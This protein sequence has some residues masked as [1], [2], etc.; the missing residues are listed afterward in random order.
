MTFQ[1]GDAP[2]PS[3]SALE[4]QR[5]SAE[6]PNWAQ[7]GRHSPLDARLAPAPGPVSA[8]GAK[9]R[10]LTAGLGFGERRGSAVSGPEPSHND[11]R[12]P[13]RRGCVIFFPIIRI[14]ARLFL[15]RPERTRHDRL[16]ARTRPLPRRRAGSAPLARPGFGAGWAVLCGDRLPAGSV[17]EGAMHEDDVLD[18]LG[19]CR[20]DDRR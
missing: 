1:V 4:A 6:R 19:P 16:R 11:D 14:C 17:G 5:P 15:S 13:D 18:R 7:T 9:R 10:D 12:P 2:P 8:A 20:S 3:P